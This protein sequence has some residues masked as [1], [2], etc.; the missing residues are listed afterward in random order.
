MSNP[1]QESCCQ[2]GNCGGPR[3][4]QLSSNELIVTVAKEEAETPEIKQIGGALKKLMFKIEG[5]CCASEVETVKGALNPLIR[6][7]DSVRLSF[8]VINA[9]ITLDSQFNN[10]PSPEEIKKAI[11]KTG[12]K[13]ILWADHVKQSG[14][15]K[16]FWKRYGHAVMNF[17]SGITLVAGF[18]I[19]LVISGIVD[20]LGG[21]VGKE[22][23]NVLKT[24][25]SPHWFYIVSPSSQE[26]GLFSPRQSAL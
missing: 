14:K 9:K 18:I 11:A 1:E 10:L 16:S 17:A 15:K 6:G 20:T 12:M 23:R 5:M 21:E 13:A 4:D 22:V 8:D 19:H 26:D 7:K 2:K 3:R 24:R 25:Q